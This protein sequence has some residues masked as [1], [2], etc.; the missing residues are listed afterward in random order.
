[1]IKPW[2]FAEFDTWDYNGNYNHSN[3]PDGIVDMVFVVSRNIANEYSNPAPIYNALNMGR[4][5]DLGGS[6]FTVDNGL[7]TIK[8]GFWPIGNSPGGSGATMTDWF[9]EDMFRFCIH[10]FGHYL[11]GGNDQHVGYGFWGLLSGWGIKS[12]V[13]NAFERYRLGWINLN[14]IQASPNQT[15][16]N[17]TLP[18]YLTTGVA[19]RLVIDAASNQY[20][21]IENHQN[22]NRWKYPN[23]TI[24]D[25]I[26]ILRQDGTGGDNTFI[27]LIPA[28]GRW[29]WTVNQLTPNP[30]GA[31]DL[32]V[33]K[34]LTA[35]RV[36]GYHDLQF[37]PWIWN[38]VNQTP[39]A[40]HF[41]ENAS[42]QPVLDVRYPGDGKDAF[43]LTFNE[44]WSP[45]SNPNSQKA[46]K[47]ATPFGVKLNSLT[48]GVYSINI[49]VNTS[50]NAPP[51]KPINFEAN[52]SGTHPVLT[53]D[54]NIESDISG[55]RV[56]KKLITQ[57]SG[58]STSYVFTT[59]TTYTDND[60]TIATGR[61]AVDNA[62]YW[63]VAVDN[64][65]NLSV[66]TEHYNT[67]GNSSIQ[68]KIATDEKENIAKEFGLFPNYP[69]P[70]NP[71]T[72]ISYQIKEKGLVQ[73][74]VYDLLGSEVATLVNEIKSEG[75]YSVNF[76]ASNLPSGIYIYSFRVNDF[77]QNNKMTLLK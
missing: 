23:A 15:I 77:V 30:W 35:D 67:S 10:E 41:T 51:S 3:Q 42:G 11:E 40:I 55:Y 52:F 34:K 46:N 14:T 7:R 18:D 22:H 72:T 37:I 48:N 50:L 16:Q 57:S 61:F 5:G 27:Q 76:D 32:P 29:N 21:Y 4:Y 73:I 69:N 26:Y 24:E 20:F 6:Q 47:T 65:S 63:I 58:T 59:S 8:T 36:N 1:M 12:Y 2:D 75:E 54:A 33:F 70:F 60:F 13:A 56:Y 25:G 53:W 71:V 66:G 45:Y 9:T 74:K 49:Y 28:D 64:N 68:W 44:I 38:G 31:G 62:E 43:R 39:H 19:Y 17:A